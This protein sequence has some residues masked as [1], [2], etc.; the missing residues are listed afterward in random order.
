[1]KTRFSRVP[2]SFVDMSAVHAST[3]SA[4][5]GVLAAL[6]TVHPELVEGWSVSLL[7]PFQIGCLYRAAVLIMD[8]TELVEPTQSGNVGRDKAAGRSRLSLCRKRFAYSG[9]Q[10]WPQQVKMR[11]AV[12]RVP[13]SLVGFDSA[14]AS[15]GHGRG[16]W[17]EEK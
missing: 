5:T 11:I 14:V 9:L 13:L 2:K 17:S 6:R 10:V 1:M 15:L 16:L 3:G 7:S 4:R 8:R 12:Y